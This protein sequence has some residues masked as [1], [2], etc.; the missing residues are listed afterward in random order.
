MILLIFGGVP[1]MLTII[2]FVHSV[3]WLTFEPHDAILTALEQQLI[4][5]E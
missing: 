3:F 5:N 4:Y 2:T 1:T